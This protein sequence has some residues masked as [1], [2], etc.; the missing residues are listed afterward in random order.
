MERQA[1]GG[2]ATLDAI[3]GTG[4]F[5]YEVGSERVMSVVVTEFDPETGTAKGHIHLRGYGRREGWSYRS[6][7]GGEFCLDGAPKAWDED[8]AVAA[9]NRLWSVLDNSFGGN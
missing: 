6:G 2:T 3:T 4:R 8:Y 1:S 7:C 9:H 5:E